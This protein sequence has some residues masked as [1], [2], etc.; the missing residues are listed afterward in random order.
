MRILILNQPFHPD[1]V[2]TAQIAKDL[3][4]DLVARGHNVTA[5]ASRS[6]YGQSGASLPKR[7]TVDGIEII[8][9]GVS[10]FG[11]KSTLGRLAD[12][13][14]Y[15]IQAALRGLF[16][17]RFDVVICLTTPPYIAIVGLLMRTFRGSR[18]V[19]WLMDIYPDVMAAHGMLQERSLLYRFLR[20]LHRSVL[21]RV[22]R[23][24]VLGRCMR[25]RLLDQGAS[26]DG[27]EVVPVWSVSD[28]DADAGDAPAP[29][30][31]YRV[32]WGVDDRLLIMY[33]G[34]F[35]LA[36][37]VDTFLD[38][39][40]RMKA[41][42]RIRFAFVGGGKRK[43][44]VEAS[45][46]DRGLSNCILA[47]YQPR[48]RLADLLAAADIQLVTMLPEWWGLVVPSKFFGV[49]AA[50]RPVLFIGP[51][52]SEIGRSIEE[53]DCGERF[54]PGESER[55]AGVL[56]DLAGR[57]SDLGPMGRRGRERARVAASRRVCAGRIVEIVEELARP[58]ARASVSSDSVAPG[59]GEGR[60]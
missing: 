17:R 26:S 42:D 43:G 10:V 15:Y 7:E 19:Y 2:A 49:A 4:D 3:A 11:K 35:G 38:A 8:R 13:A 51:E 55:L 9:V 54:S 30:N 41:D 14:N 47:E 12:F 44:D 53:W 36:H 37:D 18:V 20:R 59:S 23:T 39:A 6:I 1:V 21:K 27:I 22:D 52:Q 25:Q 60:Y 31:P 34:N 58:G 32:E 57:R 5:I 40:E 46:R 56:T 50:G 45:V 24:I 29:D 16:M 33:S 48:E 28:D